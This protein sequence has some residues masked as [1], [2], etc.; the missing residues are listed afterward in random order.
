MI[1]NMGLRFKNYFACTYKTVWIPILLLFVVLPIYVY[2]TFAKS[3]GTDAIAIE[4]TMQQGISFMY[5]ICVI[6]STISI[7]SDCTSGFGR[8]LLYLYQRYRVF[9]GVVTLLFYVLCMGLQQC[10]F[11][12]YLEMPLMFF[13]KNV[14]MLVCFSGVCYCSIFLFHN[15]TQALVFSLLF[16]LLTLTQPMGL[17]DLLNYVDNRFGSLYAILFNEK[18][19]LI[20]GVLSWGCGVFAN[21]YYKWYD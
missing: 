9:E 15:M 3:G 16:F 10:F 19:Y 17:F 21:K 12:R 14:L 7:F 6:L 5:P 20:V 11:G 8:E 2:V 13:F 1:H 4:N 18:E